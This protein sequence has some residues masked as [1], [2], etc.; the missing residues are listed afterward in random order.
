M[1]LVVLVLGFCA[2]YVFVKWIT[3]RPQYRG[4]SIA[5]LGF[6]PIASTFSS[7]TDI[8]IVS[9][10]YWAGQ[11]K[12]L[13]VNLMDIYAVVVLLTTPRRREKSPLLI[14]ILLYAAAVAL[15][16]LQSREITPTLFYLW[17]QIK[18]V[19]LF[20]G[21]WRL[22]REPR[23]SVYIFYGLAAGIVVEAP[24]A[25]YQ[26][27]IL[28]VFQTY[29]TFIHQNTLGMA[30]HFFF[31][32]A[33]ML[34]LQYRDR[35]LFLGLAAASVSVILTASRGSIGIMAVCTLV[36]ILVSLWHGVDKA[37]IRL[38]FFIAIVASAL[39]PFAYMQLEKRYMAMEE[40]EG[41][42]ERAA[43]IGAARLILSDYPMGIGAN[44]YVIAANQGGYLDA[45]GVAATQ[46]SRSTLVHN[47]YWLTLAEL[48][49]VGFAVFMLF[50][51]VP[52]LKGARLA[53]KSRGSIHGLISSG[54]TL[55]PYGG[56]RA[57]QF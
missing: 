8:A 34:W 29:G 28:G 7:Y 42:D 41:Y 5:L 57:F 30:L 32:P 16:L 36:S 38:V 48:G 22:L 25:V 15:S 37:K 46:G 54:V 26:R 45:A 3:S 1:K 2:M 24:V 18:L 33:V 17:Q 12:G 11:T 10:P 21:V 14:P 23:D 31:Y 40:S 43:F 35:I 44:N 49:Y 13:Q 39:S 27:F 19:I 56:C 52:I 47:M 4:L 53:Q 6:L 20:F 9:W 50:I 51:I 55:I